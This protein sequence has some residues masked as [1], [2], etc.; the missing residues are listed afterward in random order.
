T[1]SPLALET[2]FPQLRGRLPRAVLTDLP[3]PV[4]RLQHLGDELAGSELWIKRDDISSPLY[5]GN[6]PRKLELLLGRA[7]A[8]GKTTLLTT[9]GIGTHHGL[10]TAVCGRALG[11]RTILVLL[12]QPVTESV[13]RCLLLDHAA[14]AELHWAPNVPKLTA[15]ALRLVS[16]ESLRGSPPYIIATGGTSTIGTIGYVNA[17]FELAEQIERGE[18]PEPSQIF[19]PTGSGGT[20]AGLALGLKLAGLRSRV[21]GVVVT[22]ILP[23]SAARIA[24]L[25]RAAALHLHQHDESLPRVTVTPDDFGMLWNYVGAGYGH[26]TGEGQQAL[27][28]LRELEGITLDTTYTAKTLAAVLDGVRAQRFG[29]GPLLFWN[30][31]SS[32]DPADHLGPLP[33]YRQL[34]QPFHRFFE[35]KAVSTSIGAA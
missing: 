23:P 34:P 2:R 11:L 33:D 10:A 18:L 29:P 9:G 1:D 21:V 20:L 12:E 31:Y 15:C 8:T 16:R 3:T 7:V 27:A 14:G 13:R 30:T 4:A 26:P 22:D 25:A 17:A 24:R 19:V 6:K 32:I 35:G 5:G 28:M